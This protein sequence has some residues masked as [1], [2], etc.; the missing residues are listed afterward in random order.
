MSIKPGLRRYR[1]PLAPIAQHFQP[2]ILRLVHALLPLLLRVRIFPWLPAGI[3]SVEAEGSETLARCYHDFGAGRTRLILAVRHCEVDDPLCAL[4]LLSRTLPRQARGMGLS[5]PRPCHAHVLFDRGMTLWGGRPLGWMLSW[6]GGVSLRRGRQPDWVALRQARGLVLDGRL[7]FAVA[8][9]GATNGHGERIGPLEPG[10]VQLGLWCL[11]DLDRAGRREDVVI[12]PIGLRYVYARSEWWRLDRLMDRLE[13]TVGLD[14]LPRRQ[15][16]SAPGLQD[17]Y[18]RLVRL[19]EALIERLDRFYARYRPAVPEP[20]PEIITAVNQGGGSV[21]DGSVE[22]S[23]S[24]EMESLGPRI[25][26]LISVALAAAESRLGERTTGGTESRCRRL[27]ET[28]WRWIHRE[29]LPPRR[30]LSRLDR[31]LADRA[32]LEASLAEVHMR[33]A[34]SFV[35][36]SGSYVAERP[37]FERFMETTLLIHDGIQRLLGR[38]LPRR[39]PLGARRAIVTIGEPL[40]LRERRRQ[41]MLS[42]ATLSRKGMARQMIDSLSQDIRRAFLEGIERST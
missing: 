15:D 34:E 30:R 42:R 8:P 21:E 10:V 1:P 19:G 2:W 11:E 22:D 36:V 5:I 37:S 41:V 14:P 7:P 28:A 29:D 25:R 16:G 20:V 23:S 17:R 24:E 13:T 18:A 3:C 33:L 4:H 38:G 26:S 31:S 6:L 9:E 12:L 39:P 32:A 40:S 27:E 35:A